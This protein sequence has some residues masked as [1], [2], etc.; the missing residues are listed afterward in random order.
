MVGEMEFGDIFL[1]LED[2]DNEDSSWTHRNSI[3]Y[4]IITYILFVIFLI[5]MAIIIMNLLV[6][7][8]VDDIKAVQEQAV[9]KRLAMQVWHSCLK[10]L[11]GL[12]G[13]AACFGC[14]NEAQVL[15]SVLFFCQQVELAL[16]V[17]SVVPQ[18]I[19]RKFV[20]K[21]ETIT[22]NNNQGN[23]IKRF[24]ST[25]STFMSATAI[26]KALNP[27]LVC[28]GPLPCLVYPLPQTAP[29]A[30]QTPYTTSGLSVQYSS[31][32][33]NHHPWCQLKMVFVEGWSLLSGI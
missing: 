8:A 21:E 29:P 14:V 33:Y 6:G 4:Q 7:L 24:F 17:E 10:S 3:Y 16:D 11:Q 22:P 25:T 1:K 15:Q 28:L 13:G 23:F 18:F 26:T 9:L 31:S 20:V 30:P 5:L 2:D 32:L 19:R 12:G 27:E